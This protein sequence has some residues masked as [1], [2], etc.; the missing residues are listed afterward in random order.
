MSLAWKQEFRLAVEERFDWP[1][2]L[3]A[4]S[5]G[6]NG[7]ALAPAAAA[8]PAFEIFT[9]SQD[10]SSQS[11]EATFDWIAQLLDLRIPAPPL[12]GVPLLPAIGTEA[13]AQSPA[14]GHSPP[15]ADSAPD[16]PASDGPPADI[17]EVL[18]AAWPTM[19]QMLQE[20]VFAAFPEAQF[21]APHSAPALIA[22]VAAGLPPEGM[23]PPADAIP[24]TP[25]LD[26]PG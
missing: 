1:A 7:S 21:K 13:A 3:R 19:Q 12:S 14:A 24:L 11:A 10:S 17:A 5:Q 4:S 2:L 18:A 22:D 20:A 6:E 23:L 26:F 8:P 15:A 25:G 9:L 16:G